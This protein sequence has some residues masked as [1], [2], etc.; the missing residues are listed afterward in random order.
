MAY[1]NDALTKIYLQERESR[2]SGRNGTIEMISSDTT[3]DN[4]DAETQTEQ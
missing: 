4:T 2:N 3:N 1:I